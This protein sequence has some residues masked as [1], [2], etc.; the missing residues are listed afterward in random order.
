MRFIP[1]LVQVLL[2]SLPHF[3]SIRLSEEEKGGISGGASKEKIKVLLWSLKA[4]KAPG[5]NRLH[6]GFFQRFWLVV[7][8]SMIEEVKRIFV[9]RKVL[10]YLN[11]IFIAF[12]PKF[13]VPETLCN[14]RLI[15]LCNTVYKIVS[16]IV[17]AR[18]RP[19]LD[20]LISPSQTTFVPGRKGIDNAIIV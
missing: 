5:P 11:R 7:S 4:F 20:M 10:E 13:Q 9:D 19:S 3:V 8:N 15:N 16:K 18:L 14:Y 6:A 1:L 12:I 2:V 17:V